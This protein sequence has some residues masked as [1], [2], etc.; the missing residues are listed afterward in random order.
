MILSIWI[1]TIWLSGINKLT[2]L[3]VAFNDNVSTTSKQ[4]RNHVVLSTYIS[5]A[6]E[7]DLAIYY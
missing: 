6:F 3:Q 1:V 2:K 5:T 7:V 4:R